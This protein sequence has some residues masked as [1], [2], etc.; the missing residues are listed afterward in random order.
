[1][2]RKKGKLKNY[3]VYV[4][5]DDEILTSVVG[6]PLIKNTKENLIEYYGKYVLAVQ[7]EIFYGG[8]KVPV[9][10]VSV[11][12]VVT[13]YK[14]SFGGPNGEL[15]ATKVKPVKDKHWK[16]LEKIIHEK[17]LRGKIYFWFSSS[18]Y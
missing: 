7:Q 16:S 18:N 3:K 6:K 4:H 10:R 2:P 12:G 5:K 14:G 8:S 9:Y 1:M 11:P 15:P 13:H 17:G